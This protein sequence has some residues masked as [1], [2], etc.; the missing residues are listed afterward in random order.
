MCLLE[1]RISGF[2]SVGD[3]VFELAPLTLL[4]GPPSSGKSNVV[5]GFGLASIVGRFSL[6]VMS[7]VCDGDV[8]RDRDAFIRCVRLLLSNVNDILRIPVYVGGARQFNVDSLR[9]LHA[10]GEVGRVARVAIGGLEVS[11][12]KSSIVVGDADFTPLLR[13][14]FEEMGRSE[15]S[16]DP[17][18]EVRE[19][20]DRVTQMVGD[21][22]VVGV[23]DFDRFKVGYRLERLIAGEGEWCR[24]VRRFLLEDASNL[25]MVLSGVAGFLVSFNELLENLGSPVRLILGGEQDRVYRAV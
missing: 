11:V 9:W 15:L 3:V 25:P 2:K 8:E 4:V 19:V 24:H 12:T 10:W 16:Y 14:A 17:Y 18:S 21:G 1:V 22:L 23:Y 5:D 20:V 13:Y 7:G 6:L